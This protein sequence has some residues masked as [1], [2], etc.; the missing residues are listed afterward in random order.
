MN[1]WTPLTSANDPFETYP[2][3]YQLS[4]GRVIHVG[5][6]EVAT[7][8]DI[9]DLKAQSW[10][11][12]DPNIADGGSAAMYLPGKIMKAGSAPTARRPDRRQIRRICSI[13]LPS[14]QPGNRHPQWPILEAFSIYPSC[15]ME[16]F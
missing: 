1:A 4:D 15:P 7:V 6:S 3:L 2:F 10:S 13:Q 8:T 5:N 9:L 14:P 12:L 11:V 16:R